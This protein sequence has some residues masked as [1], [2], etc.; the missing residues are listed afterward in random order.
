MHGLNT[1]YENQLD[2]LYIDVSTPDG[3]QAFKAAELAG[4]PAFLILKG[5][6]T[7]LWR[8][9]GQQTEQALS[10]AIDKAL[11]ESLASLPGTP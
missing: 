7:E 10:D 2:F 9:I 5:D 11:Q 8:A 6:G 3:Q 1:T 4:H